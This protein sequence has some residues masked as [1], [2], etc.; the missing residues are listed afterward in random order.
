MYY[1]TKDFEYLTARLACDLLKSELLDVGQVHAQPVQGTEYLFHELN[2][3]SFEIHIP[4]IQSVWQKVSSPNLPW[5]EEHFQERVSGKPLNPPPSSDYWPFKKNGHNDHLDET[6][7][8]SHTYPERFWPKFAGTPNVRYANR[9]I[10]YHYGDLL[11]VVNLLIKSPLT[12]QAFLPVWFPEDT[13]SVLGQRVPCSLGYH[14]MIRN[15][16]LNCTYMLRSCDFIR[17][18]RDDI[19]MAGR[20]MQWVCERFNAR[21]F[22]EEELLSSHIEPGYLTT[23]IMNLHAF[24]GDQLTL[25]KA[26]EYYFPGN[27]FQDGYVVE[28]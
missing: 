4:L 27:Y 26:A 3:I 9:G 7:K 13:G 20:L 17:H 1:P 24:A 10:R 12:R 8:F 25:R 18:F 5:A 11:D 23:H 21:G 28:D 16:F 19:Y 22:N 14:F 15:G 6:R 2:G